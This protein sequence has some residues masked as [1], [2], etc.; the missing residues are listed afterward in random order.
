LSSAADFAYPSAA[1]AQLRAVRK[2]AEKAQSC[3][4]VDTVFP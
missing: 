4:H 1:R 2:S 3:R